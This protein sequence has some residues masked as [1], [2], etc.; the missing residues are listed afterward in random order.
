VVLDKGLLKGYVCMYICIVHGVSLWNI[1][2]SDAEL[3]SFSTL[4]LSFGQH[5]CKNLLQL[6]AEVLSWGCDM[7]MV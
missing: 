3:R 2:T 4:T 6:L 7:E 5:V 1:V